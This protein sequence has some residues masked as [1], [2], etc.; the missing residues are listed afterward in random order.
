MPIAMRPAQRYAVQSV[1]IHGPQR[2][3]GLSYQHGIHPPVVQSNTYRL[4]SSARGH[5]AFCEFGSVEV[6]QGDNAPKLIYER[7]TSP[8][9][10]LLQDQ[11]VTMENGFSARV[12]ATGMGAINAGLFTVL[13]ARRGH[14]MIAD[15]MLYGCT[16]SLCQRGLPKRGIT[17]NPVNTSDLNSLIEVITRKD[18]KTRVIYFESPA[19]PALRLTDML[20]LRNIVDDVNKNRDPQDQ[21]ILILDSTFAT[22]YSQNPLNLGIDILIHSLTKNLNGFGTRMGGAVIIND[23]ERFLTELDMELKDG[24]AVMLDQVAW[25]FLTYSIPTFIPR[26]R[27]KTET[28]MRLARFLEEHPQ[29]GKGNVVFPGLESFPQYELAQKQM[30]NGLARKFA[31]GDMIYFQLKRKQDESREA[32]L[33]RTAFFLDSIADDSYAVTLGVSLGL[34]KTMIESPALMTHSS[35]TEDQLIQSGFLPGGM[36]LAP[37]GEDPKDIESDL[38][39]GLEKAA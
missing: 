24:G 18:D 26:M 13:D 4:E 7:L 36:R 2:T 12:F 1:L 22:P 39:D 29:V 10:V 37:G 25:D 16:F 28:A 33:T 23:Q 9:K 21:I 5:Q 27:Q 15:T 14:T 30:S 17:V 35:Y 11:L 32:Y 8:N 6:E 34:W 20:A 3:R 19:N 31:P 38:D